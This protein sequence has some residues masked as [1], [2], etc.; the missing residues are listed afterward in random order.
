MVFQIIFEETVRNMVSLIFI[1]LIAVTHLGSASFELGEQDPSYANVI[2]VKT[3]GSERSYTFSVTISSPDM[4]CDQYADWWEVIDETEGLIYRRI[5]AHSHTN[6]QPFT[7]QGGTVTIES[8]ENVWIRAHMNNFGYGGSTYY[9]NV[10]EGFD[11]RE[12][13]D[14]FGQEIEKESPQPSGCAF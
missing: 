3:S 4:G 1:F 2:A 9:G 14:G 7:R 10:K 13:P 6:E 12:M 5:L 11:S 8:D